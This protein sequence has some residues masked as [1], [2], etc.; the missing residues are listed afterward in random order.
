MAILHGLVIWL[1]LVT[2]LHEVGLSIPLEGLNLVQVTQETSGTFRSPL[3]W[4]YMLVRVL[5]LQFW[6]F[7]IIVKFLHVITNQVQI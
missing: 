6:P 3:A 1:Q 4:I 5:S 2:L 7:T